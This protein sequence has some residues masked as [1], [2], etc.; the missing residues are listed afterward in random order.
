MSCFTEPI[1]NVYVNNQTSDSVYVY[2]A[3]GYFK[4]EYTVYP[5]TMLPKDKNLG[6][7]WDNRNLSSYIAIVPPYNDGHKERIIK[8]IVGREKMS[9]F[10]KDVL[11][12][13]TLSVFFFSPDTVRFYGYDRVAAEN[14]IWVRYDLSISDME[15]LNYIF[16]YPPTPQ[17]EHMKMYPSYRKVMES[18]SRK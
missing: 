9:D 18:A 17:M 11:P 16:P 7:K 4:D 5:D 6:P 3:T 12:L 13:D 2:L 14:R 10:F 8:E 1:K 15:M